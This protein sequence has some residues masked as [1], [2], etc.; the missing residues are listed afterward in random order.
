[1]KAWFLAG[2]VL[3]SALAGVVTLGV[4]NGFCGT[5]YEEPE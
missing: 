5:P 4:S 3:F 1:M 2:L